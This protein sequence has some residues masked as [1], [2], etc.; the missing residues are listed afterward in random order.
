MLSDII[1]NVYLLNKRKKN[2]KRIKNKKFFNCYK[3]FL[4]WTRRN[5]GSKLS[6][7]CSR[8]CP[9]MSQALYN[10]LPVTSNVGETEY[11]WWLFFYVL[12]VW[13]K[14][15]QLKT[16]GVPLEITT[17][18]LEKIKTVHIEDFPETPGNTESF[19]GSW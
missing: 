7:P 18:K 17:Y 11:V 6:L 10:T 12:P 8:Q 16:S 3:Y 1:P 2:Q 4:K 19:P 9:L 5:W 13:Q 15:L 14:R